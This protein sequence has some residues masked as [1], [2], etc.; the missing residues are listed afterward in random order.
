MAYRQKYRVSAMMGFVCL[1]KRGVINML[2]LARVN[3]F[4]LFAVICFSLVCSVGCGSPDDTT[5][6]GPE[7]PIPKELKGKKVGDKWL[8][9]LELQKGT[10]EFLKGKLTATWGANGSYLG[11]T[12]RVKEGQNVEFHVKNSV[13]ET[14]TIHWHGLHIPA[15]MDGGPHQ[16]IKPDTVWKPHFTIMQRASINWYHPH[17]EG[18]TGIHVYNGIAGLFYIDDKVSEKLAIPKEYGVDDIPLVIQDRNFNPDGSFKYVEG[19]MQKMVGVKGK[20]VLVNGAIMPTFKAPAQI[21]RFRLLNGSNARIYN[22]GFHNNRSFYMIGTEGGLLEKPVKLTRL[23]LAPGERADILL[24]LRNEKDQKISLKSFSS[25]TTAMLDKHDKTGGMHADK[26]D[27][28]DYSIMTILVSKPASKQ[29]TLPDKLTT[30]TRLSASDA[31]KTR[32]FVL[33]VKGE[34]GTKQEFLINDKSMSMKRIDEVIKLGSTEI[35]ELKN[36][37]E[38]P[39]P[40]HIHDITFLILDRNGQPPPAH[41]RGWKDTVLIKIDETVRVIAKFE[42]CADPVVP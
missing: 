2:R 21:V 1:R 28:E 23:L 17:L 19:N 9:E 32:P 6:L 41:E 18:K 25:E 35:W 22:L 12:I 16:M 24:D 8:F 13:G 37:S 33:D 42:H 5:P 34:M 31:T 27:R 30:I 11:P 14:T 7:L 10:M 4:V 26:M 36:K 39:H 20:K 3:G 40:F 38:M 15:K 29:Y